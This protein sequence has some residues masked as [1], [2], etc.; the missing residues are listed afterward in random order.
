MKTT[1][2]IE[3]TREEAEKKVLDKEI[4]DVENA[5]EAGDFEYVYDILNQG[6]VGY[7][8]FTNKEL[9]KELTAQFE[10][11]HKING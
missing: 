11:Q 2:I 6:F 10:V 7:M 9:E 4:K 5:A 8:N 3:L 1:T